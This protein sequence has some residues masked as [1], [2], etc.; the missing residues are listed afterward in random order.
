M[1]HTNIYSAR[2]RIQPTFYSDSRSNQKLT[3]LAVTPILVLNKA[4]EEKWRMEKC[5]RKNVSQEK[6]E[7]E[8]CVKNVSSLAFC[9]PYDPAHS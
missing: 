7:W 2:P 1:P 8:K 6:W 5:V 4:A 9:H 3:N